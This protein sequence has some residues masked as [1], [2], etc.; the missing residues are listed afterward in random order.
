MWV[1]SQL[2]CDDVSKVLP[3]S[4]EKKLFT[5]IIGHSFINKFNTVLEF[6]RASVLT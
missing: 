5:N 1:Y 6:N 4:W 2:V 3:W